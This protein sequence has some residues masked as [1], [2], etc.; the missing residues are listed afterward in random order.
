[1]NIYQERQRG[2]MCRLH[3][4]NGY[5]G[6]TILNDN[7]FF[8]YCDEYDK[9]IEGLY[10]RNMDGFAEGR[11][12]VSYI[13]DKLDN[14]YV[15]LIPIDSYTNARKH[16]D[17]NRYLKIIN[18]LG[19]YFEFNKDHV[20]V[21]KKIENRL[22]KID[23]LSGVHEINQINKFQKRHG[24]LLV[25]DD[26][27]LYKELEY[28]IEYLKKIEHQ[29][30]FNDNH[31]ILFCNLYHLLRHIPIDIKSANC[32][33]AKFMEKLVVINNIKN[34]LNEFIKCRRY[35][36]KLDNYK[37]ILYKIYNLSKMVD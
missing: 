15:L 10:S 20:W 17:L 36:Y 6:N 8:E 19:N 11:S 2:N 35:N 27:L 23:S 18:L 22:Y 13:I 29:D 37:K 26:K 30:L 5:F 7:Q 1:M 14:K 31:E 12:I 25:I 4:I 3:A 16:I 9:I 21:N 24:Y 33:D 32:I 28:Y 34:T